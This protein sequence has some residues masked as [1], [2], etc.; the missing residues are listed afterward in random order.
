MDVDE[1]LRAAA[2]R[3][4]AQV[5]DPALGQGIALGE[6]AACLAAEEQPGTDP[7]VVLGMLDGLAEGLHVP[8]DLPEVQRVA[9]LGHHLFE[10]LGFGG[11]LDDYGDPA[12]SFLDRVIERRKGLPILLSVVVIEVGRR[13]GVTIDGVG[14][15][16]HFLVRPRDVDPPFFIDPYHQGRIVRPDELGARLDAMTGG[17]RRDLLEPVGPREILLRMNRNLK[18]A[19]LEKRDVHAVLRA[20]E[21]LLLLDPGLVDE[22]R[23]RALLLG[24]LGR[25]DTAISELEAWLRLHPDAPESDR[26]RQHLAR[27]LARRS[28]ASG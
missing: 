9:R 8:A 1:I 25:L 2:R 16:G 27:L 19:W 3:R 11:D 24:Q 5:V 7:S 18:Q 23:D 26:L 13:V 17:Q 4:F 15:P 10:A 22:R 12:N 14:F 28:K 21:R 20:I 6:A